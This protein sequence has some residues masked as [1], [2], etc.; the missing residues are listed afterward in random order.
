MTPLRQPNQSRL[1]LAASVLAVVCGATFCSAKE[2]RIGA[3]SVSSAKRPG[4]SL[5]EFT[6]EMVTTN[7]LSDVLNILT[8]AVRDSEW[9]DGCRKSLPLERSPPHTL[10]KL[11]EY[12]LPW[13]VKPFQQPRYAVIRTVSK[14]DRT[15]Q[16]LSISY[17]SVNRKV[18]DHSNWVRSE[19]TGTWKLTVLPGGR[20]KIWHRIWADFKFDKKWQTRVNRQM[21]ETVLNSFKKLRALLRTLPADPPDRIRSPQ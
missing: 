3:I 16:A 21:K 15:G 9:L 18:G 14:M 11:H 20:L 2:V 5:P 7:S 10:V 8:N 12:E 4:S 19:L 1:H 17:R 13:Y 6:V